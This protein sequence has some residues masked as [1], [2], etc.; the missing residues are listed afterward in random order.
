M[1]WLGD[2]CCNWRLVVII[3]TGG[4]GLAAAIGDRG[5]VRQLPGRRQRCGLVG[6]I[7]PYFFP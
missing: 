5:W 4:A 3:D 2:S 1:L 6:A 7:T